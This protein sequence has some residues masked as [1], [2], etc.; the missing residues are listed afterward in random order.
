MYKNNVCVNV[1]EFWEGFDGGTTNPPHTEQSSTHDS[2]KFL[3]FQA[4]KAA[5]SHS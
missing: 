2:F 3:I 4:A 5:N 1:K